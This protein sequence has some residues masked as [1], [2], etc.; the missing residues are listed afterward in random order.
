[1]IS[2]IQSDS[3][4]YKFQF[5]YYRR[6]RDAMKD[7][8][9]Q[10]VKAGHHSIYIPGYI[11]WS[12]KEG[13]GIFDPLNSIPKL[14]RHYYILDRQLKIQK[15]RLVESLQDH[16]ILL[17]VNYFGF[18]DEQS[19]EIIHLAHDR[20]CIVIE[21]NAHGFYTYF[22]NGSC[23]SD[24]TFFS[25]HKMFPFREG[26]GLLIENQSLG[27]KP[28][29]S[30]PKPSDQDPFSYHIQEIARKRIANFRTLMQLAEGK[31]KYFVPLKQLSDIET[32]VPQTFPIIIQQGDRNR[33]YEIMN[34]SGYGVVSL[35]HTMIEELRTEQYQDARWVS[36]H[37]MNL[38]LH[39]DC[40]EKEFSMMIDALVN[41][42]HSNVSEN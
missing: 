23:G 10:L 5:F 16:S 41:L 32:N 15:N 42:I 17:L 4:H 14:E 20:N 24:V 7:V 40:D 12:P 26:G 35:Y 21:D 11:G 9:G 30:I 38:P 39:Q 13:S 28:T 34:A 3:D 1:M 8:V 29:E 36:D 27:I 18:R 19:S 22:C 6:A 37:I 33:I 25:L 31:E 2:K